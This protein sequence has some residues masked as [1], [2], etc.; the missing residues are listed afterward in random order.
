MK[1]YDIFISHAS[2]DKEIIVRELANRL[3]N[4]G[5]SVWYDEFSLKAGDSLREKI[6]EGLF[7]SLCG[8]LVL[9]P[10]FFKKNWP[11]KELNGL[12][13]I[14]SS[15]MNKI[16]P[17]WH[18]V[19]KEEVMH[20]SPILA[21]LVSIN[22]NIGFEKTIEKIL[23]VV[24]PKILDNSF[25]SLFD[26]LRIARVTSFSVRHLLSEINS[27]FNLTQDKYKLERISSAIYSIEKGLKKLAKEE[28]KASLPKEALELLQSI[29]GDTE[30]YCVKCKGKQRIAIQTSIV[31]KNGR[32]GTIGLCPICGTSMFRIGGKN[33]SPLKAK[34]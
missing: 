8:L 20:Y 26:I 29:P 28:Q 9:S 22:S 5:L 32:N 18:R 14:N 2:E 33:N 21:D 16:I 1:E 19:S 12:M 3:S 7:N 25:V 6:D 15:N 30:G 23:E 24:D 10:N 27:T 17:I 31:M 13:S 4:Y 34:N 11:K